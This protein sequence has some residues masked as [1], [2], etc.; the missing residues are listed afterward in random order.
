MRL[1][2]LVAMVGVIVVIV[3]LGSSGSGP[4]T[5]A[6]A[7]NAADHAKAAA[8][9]AT[10]KAAK[11][12]KLAALRRPFPSLEA[13]SDAAAYLEHRQGIT[14]Y[15]VVNN[16]GKEYGLNDH[17]LYLSA[18]TMKSMLLVGYLRLLS[19]R[20][21][22]LTGQAASLLQPM[23]NV[24]DNNAAEAVWDIVGNSGLEHVADLAGMT[25][26]T[27]GI[28]WA[29]EMISCADMARFF[30]K[31]DSLIPRQFR[32]Y[33]RGLLAGVATYES[34]GVP[35]AARPKWKVFFKGGWRGTPQGQLVS[36]IARLEQPGRRIAIAVMTN[37]DPSMVYGE[38][39]IAGVAAQLLGVRMPK[40]GAVKGA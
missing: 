34:W 38:D 15:A 39:T 32:S 4:R 23:I 12:R 20:H 7:K 11:Q 36:Q 17:R 31:M 16:K 35:A 30:Y 33:A 19:E 22:Q 13:M 29:N 10:K 18:S 21:E 14:S 27:S 25:D 26:Y 2:A 5:T 9:A 8:K 6:A 40:V 3:L 1:L 37:S 28:D 24:S